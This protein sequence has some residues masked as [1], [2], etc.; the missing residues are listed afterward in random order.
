MTPEASE[1]GEGSPEQRLARHGSTARDSGQ[2]CQN[3]RV[4]QSPVEKEMSSAVSLGEKVV[5]SKPFLPF[6]EKSHKG[7]MGLEG[8]QRTTAG[9]MERSRVSFQT[10]CDEH[11]SLQSELVRLEAQPLDAIRSEGGVPT[12]TATASSGRQLYAQ[13][14]FQELLAATT[15]RDQSLQTQL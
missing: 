13:H 5:P 1:A 3:G 11:Q 8:L 15:S 6:W 10:L 7:I 4:L 12:Q 9:Q 2:V 14:Q